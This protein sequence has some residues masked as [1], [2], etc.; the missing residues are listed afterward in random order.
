[1]QGGQSQVTG[2]VRLCSPYWVKKEQTKQVVCPFIL[3]SS[4]GMLGKAACLAPRLSQPCSLD[5]DSH[6]V[7]AV[8]FLANGNSNSDQWHLHKNARITNS[9]ITVYYRIVHQCVVKLNRQDFSFSKPFWA[10]FKQTSS[11]GQLA[12]KCSHSYPLVSFI[13]MYFCWSD[14]WGCTRSFCLT[15]FACFLSLPLESCLFVEDIL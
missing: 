12:V 11:Q 6:V 15:S 14:T 7:K 5:T 10:T 4:G 3:S 2:R 1:M 8:R 13:M 9:I